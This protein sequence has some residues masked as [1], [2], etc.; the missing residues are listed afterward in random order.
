MERILMWSLSVWNFVSLSIPVLYL[1]I[2]IICTQLAT[3][4][5]FLKWSFTATS[6]FLY[7]VVLEVVLP[8]YVI[9]TRLW[10]QLLYISLISAIISI[11]L[12]CSL[13]SYLM[14]TSTLIFTCLLIINCI[15]MLIL[16]S[17]CIDTCVPLRQRW[18]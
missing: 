17:C 7:S 3:F 15:Y 1:P 18:A 14:S 11:C 5:Y 13:A 4:K 12:A 6:L 8:A 9:S 10:V 16:R 2:V